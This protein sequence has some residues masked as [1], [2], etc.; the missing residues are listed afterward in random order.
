[1]VAE[2]AAALFDFTIG[3]GSK[4]LQ[5]NVRIDLAIPQL[6]EDLGKTLSRIQTP[7]DLFPDGPLIGDDEPQQL[8]RSLASVSAGQCV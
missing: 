4:A 5:G 7:Q 8:Q 2:P 6:L 1:M 3:F